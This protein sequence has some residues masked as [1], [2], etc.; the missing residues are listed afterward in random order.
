MDAE[1]DQLIQGMKEKKSKQYTE[2][3]VTIKTS[4][5]ADDGHKI[6]T[7]QSSDLGEGTNNISLEVNMF[8]S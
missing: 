4:E 5:I 8:C 7:P 2:G 6:R 1:L 3:A